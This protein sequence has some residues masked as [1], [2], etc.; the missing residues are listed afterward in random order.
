MAEEKIYIKNKHLFKSKAQMVVYIILF[1]VLLYG[2]IYLGT[3]DYKVEVDD[4]EKVAS[5]FT[6]VDKDN[7]FK[8]VNATEARMVA[9]GKKGIVVF[10]TESKWVNYYLYMVN[11]VA[12]EV[13]ITEIYYYDFMKNRKD[14]NATYEDIVAK[15]SDYVLYNDLDKAEIYAPS[16]LV[17]GDKDVLLFDTETNFRT[18]DIVPSKYWTREKMT[19][20]MD[21]LRIIFNTYL[22]D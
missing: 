14:N 6:M 13:G 16:L 11:K 21:S 15:L 8:L 5:M 20:K 1:I 18:G 17:M 2:F 4:K 19:E 9:N 10:G 3:K 12:K 7:V 22:E